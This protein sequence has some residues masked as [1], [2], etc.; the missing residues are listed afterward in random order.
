MPVD[1][2]RVQDVF[3]L[4]VEAADAA[5]RAALLDR[6]CGDDAELRQRVEALLLAH[7]AAGS[8]L[9]RPAVQGGAT[10]AHE[11]AVLVDPVQR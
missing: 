6:A 4:A 1:A 8:F 2:Q 11:I 3:L 5:S 10:V 7:D 9:D